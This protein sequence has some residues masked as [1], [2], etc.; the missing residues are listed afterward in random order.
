MVVTRR[1][2]VVNQDDVVWLS[3]GVGS[4]VVDGVESAPAFYEP[5]GN[6]VVS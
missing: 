2:I 4:E 3:L 5:D 1:P 6:G